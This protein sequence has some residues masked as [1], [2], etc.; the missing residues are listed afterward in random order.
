MILSLY[1]ELE[2][3][4]PSRWK[5]ALVMVLRLLRLSV[6]SSQGYHSN[7]ILLLG[8]RIEGFMCNKQLIETIDV[9]FGYINTTSTLGLNG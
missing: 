1:I 9:E 3:L 5:K 7:S 4:L 8:G 2:Q 6:T